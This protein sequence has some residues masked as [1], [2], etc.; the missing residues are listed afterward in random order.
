MGAPK[1]A[2]GA[3]T[4][5]QVVQYLTPCIQYVAN[6][7]KVPDNCCNGIRTLWKSANN[8]PDR[9]GVCKC[10]KQAINGIPYSAYN[11]NLAAGLPAKCGVNLPY[12]INPS[13]NCDRVLSVSSM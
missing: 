8:T 7:G 5:G 2:E 13:T 6:G 10:L 12:K 11:L 4:C 3:V 9:V 1:V